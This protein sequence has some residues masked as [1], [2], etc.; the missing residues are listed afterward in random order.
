MDTICATFEE[1]YLGDGNYPP[2]HKGQK[3]NLSFYIAPAEKTLHSDEQ[4]LFEQI[5]YSDYKFSGKIIRNYHKSDKQIIIVDVG[6]FKFYIEEFDASFKASEGQF[7]SGRG[8][9][10][11]DYYIW[12]ENLRDYPEPPNI[13]Y[14]SKVERIIKVSMPER[15]IDRHENGLSS[16]ASLTTE[17]FSDN[18]MQEIE[19]M[20]NEQLSTVFYLLNLKFIDE[21]IAQTFL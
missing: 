18:E 9:L 1:W 12:V 14:N 6:H 15:F 4:Y 5:K 20:R 16:P 19:D 7:I 8:Q 3:V 11:V 2:L 21:D 17:D 10:L 13:F